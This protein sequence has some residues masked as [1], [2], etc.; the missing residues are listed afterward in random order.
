MTA[1]ESFHVGK[2][3]EDPYDVSIEVEKESDVIY[4]ISI[5]KKLKED[6]SINFPWGISFTLTAINDEEAVAGIKY[7]DL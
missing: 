1:K 6:G 2:Y 7:P 3:F 4:L 5:L